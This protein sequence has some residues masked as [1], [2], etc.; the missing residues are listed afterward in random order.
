MQYAWLEKLSSEGSIRPEARE[1]IYRDCS[2]LLKHATSDAA[3]DGPFTGMGSKIQGHLMMGLGKDIEGFVKKKLVAVFVSQRTLQQIA[4]NKAAILQNPGFKQYPEKA[5]QRFMDLARVAPT[6]A[7]HEGRAMELVKDKLHTGFSSHDMG[8]LAILQAIYTAQ[9]P[10]FAYRTD[11]HMQKKAG[12]SL[13]AAYAD[14]LCLVKE[15]GVAKG[16]QTSTVMHALR[17]MAL[18][19]TLP[20][21][22][23]VGAGA[24]KSYVASRDSKALAERLRDSY[25]RALRDSDSE[26]SDEKKLR[27]DPA[28][29]LQAFETLAHFAPHVAMQ[30]TAA[31][32]FMKRMIG[33]SE[34][35][36]GIDVDQVKGL[37]EI[38]RNMAQTNVQ[39]NPFFS[40]FTGGAEMFGLTNALSGSIKDTLSPLVQK[41]QAAMM[42]DLGMPK[43]RSDAVSPTVQRNRQNAMVNS[44]AIGVRK[45][46]K[47][48]TNA[49]WKKL[50]KNPNPNRG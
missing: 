1:Q 43:T 28:R 45:A 39:E 49:M 35:G 50:N 3:Q 10:D 16:L 8:N 27:E 32:S 4:N 15:A 31:R 14:M 34:A 17:N 5:T 44:I 41:N 21:L 33:Y 6:I 19:S 23:G 46:L 30:P 29:A 40:G 22:A 2:N 48:D 7:A 18:V 38:E 26:T 9:D 24:V 25:Q 11:Q 42:K 37:S 36:V 13:G 47:K 20:L 12:E